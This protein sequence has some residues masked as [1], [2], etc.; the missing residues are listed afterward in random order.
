MKQSFSKS[1]EGCPNHRILTQF[2]EDCEALEDAI[3]KDDNLELVQE[4]RVKCSGK[5]EIGQKCHTC[6]AAN[7]QAPKVE[8]VAKHAGKLSVITDM[9]ILGIS[10]LVGLEVHG[11]GHYIH[12]NDFQVE[13]LATDE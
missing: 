3:K 11:G 4:G 13:Q 5:V 1:C 10:N 6:R 8:L 7:P 2:A 9:R 12:E